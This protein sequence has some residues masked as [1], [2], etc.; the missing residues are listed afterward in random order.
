MCVYAQVLRRRKGT[1]FPSTV[2]LCHVC[3]PQCKTPTAN[4]A[5]LTQKDSLGVD[6]TN[7]LDYTICPFKAA[8][9]C[10]SD[11]E[12]NIHSEAAGKLIAELRN[13]VSCGIIVRVQMSQMIARS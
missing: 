2:I 1:I 3:I 12:R 4:Y 7:H 13:H 8:D 6:M 10:G 9:A 11:S 5:V